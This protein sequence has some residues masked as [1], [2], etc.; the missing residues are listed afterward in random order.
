MIKVFDNIIN[1]FEQEI[2]RKYLLEQSQWS[3]IEDVS[4]EDNL[5]QR[6][7]GFKI[8]FEDKHALSDYIQNIVTNTAKKIKLKESE[9]LEARS[10]LQLPLNKQFLGEGIDTPHLDRTEPHLVFLYYVTDSDGDTIIYN[11][12][13]K[14]KD[15]IPYFE[16]VKELKRVTPKQ[17]RVVVFNGLNWHTAEQPSNNVRCIINLNIYGKNID[18]IK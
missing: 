12:R 16:D 3:F 13:S 15:D 6:R 11:Y 8:L 18:K 14:N 10:F 2:I 7:P 9:L 17:G 5:H 1:E 4:L